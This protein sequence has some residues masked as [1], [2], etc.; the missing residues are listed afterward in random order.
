MDDYFTHGNPT[1]TLGRVDGGPVGHDDFEPTLPD[2]LGDDAADATFIELLQKRAEWG[3][4]YVVR[5][6]NFKVAVLGGAWTMRFNG[7]ACDAVKACAVSKETKEWR[8]RYDLPKEASYAARKYEAD[9]AIGLA[10]F[11]SS[12]M[13]HDL[14]IY[15]ESGR[16][17]YVLT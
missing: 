5:A 4:K 13:K 8:A 6:D 15:E 14:G 7:V 16:D 1:T 9:Y 2:I 17:D 3:A 10:L 11:W 12:R